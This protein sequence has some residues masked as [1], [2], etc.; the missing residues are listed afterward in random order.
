[1]SLYV[2]LLKHII[3]ASIKEDS[4]QNQQQGNEN[5]RNT[6]DNDLKSSE[7]KKS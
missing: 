4:Q 1:M 5:E 7:V 3:K 6:F 2:S